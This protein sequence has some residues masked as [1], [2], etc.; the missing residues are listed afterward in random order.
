[1]T[2]E[3]IEGLAIITLADSFGEKN[4][5]QIYTCPHIR[6]VDIERIQNVGFILYDAPLEREL[7]IKTI[8]KAIYDGAN[9]DLCKRV[10][11]YIKD[12]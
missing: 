1:M 10:G 12:V 5:K 2:E 8:A 3:D 7:V 4:T 9:E 11:F 6:L